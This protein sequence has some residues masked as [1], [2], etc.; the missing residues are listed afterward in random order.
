[1]ILR[2][3]AGRGVLAIG[4]ASHAWISGQLARAWGNDEFGTVEP[5]E[6]VCLAA[7]Q[8]DVGMASW[9]LIPNLD[10][11]TQ[12]PLS[13]TD[14]PLDLHMSLWREAPRRL[15]SQSRYAALL[16]SMHA[17]RLY[18]RR[19]L[20]RLAPSEAEQVRSFLSAQR[21]FQQAVGATL[22]AAPAAVARNSDLIW[23]WDSMSLAVCLD[24]A[25]FSLSAVP[26]AGGA[27]D[28]Q[29]TPDGE[30]R[31]RVEPWPFAAAAVSVHADGRRLTGRYATER[32]L[33]EALAS[34]AWETIV[35]E[36]R[37]A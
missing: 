24:W 34:A 32:A 7:E 29:L 16:V 17:V 35:F 26:T 11:T 6:E 3:E 13:F 21:E 20:K 15:L 10:P 23:T 33:R 1:M 4:Q 28:L 22:G 25:P 19:D 12:L 30:R 8:H 9:D 5:W 27:V 18:E 2:D 31:I 36:L 37:S 14:M